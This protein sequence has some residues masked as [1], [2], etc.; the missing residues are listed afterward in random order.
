M[1]LS[2]TRSAM[3]VAAAGLVLV[4][5][6]GSTEPATEVER[7]SARLNARGTANKGPAS[8]VFEYW[9]TGFQSLA[10]T[11]QRLNWPGGASGPI[12]TPVSGLRPGTGYSFR[13]CGRDS[14][15]S[16]DACAQTRTFT[17]DQPVEDSAKGGYFFT[18]AVSA[19]SDATSGPAGQNPRGN[20]T[21]QALNDPDGFSSTRFT[22]FV[23]CLEVDGNR[24]A[25]G[26]VGQETDSP[27]GEKRDATLL[28]TVEDAGFEGTDT[29]GD[30]RP[31]LGRTPPDCEGASFAGN[32]PAGP[33]SDFTVLDAPSSS[34][35]SR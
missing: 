19:A 8:S 28:L 12:S 15:Q 33:G 20:M 29:V 14:G 35:A 21:R 10:E 25:I 27:S 24:A 2:R 18:R 13:I 30:R 7:E 22:G 9:P 5:C 31:V 32:V 1:R 11:T 16:Q 4:G 3:V 17:T 6:Y 34:S 23:T 26:A